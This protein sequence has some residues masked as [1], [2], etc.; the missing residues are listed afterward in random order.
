MVV[1]A[2]AQIVLLFTPNVGT[3]LTV[4]MEFTIGLIHPFKLYTTE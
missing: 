4:T 3:G 1:L 2:P